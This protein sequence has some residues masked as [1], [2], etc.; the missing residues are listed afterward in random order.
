M[1]LPR[2]FPLA[3]LLLLGVATMVASAPLTFAAR[4]ALVHDGA[5]SVL[6]YAGHHH[7][8]MQ[9]RVQWSPPAGAGGD[10]DGLDA[11]LHLPPAHP[12]LLRD[13]TTGWYDGAS[14]L[15]LERLPVR[16][17][18]LV[19]TL[20]VAVAPS[21]SP[22][23]A[24]GEP[25]LVLAPTS[26]LWQTFGAAEFSGA[27][28]RLWPR[29]LPSRSPSHDPHAEESAGDTLLFGAGLT[30]RVEIGGA[31]WTVAVEWA[32]DAAQ[33]LLPAALYA[34]LRRAP[35]GTALVLCAPTNRLVEVVM[36]ADIDDDRSVALWPAVDSGQNTIRLGRYFMSARVVGWRVT[37]AGVVTAVVA[38]PLPD[39][40]SVAAAVLGL[41]AVALMTYVTSI[42]G[43]T[44]TLQPAYALFDVQPGRCCGAA[45]DEHEHDMDGAAGL[46]IPWA[47]T[48]RIVALGALALGAVLHGLA[49]A[50]AGGGLVI[51]TA[52]RGA[53]AKLAVATASVAG[54]YALLLLMALVV[55]WVGSSRSRRLRSV[56]R[57]VLGATLA[58]VSARS[59][60]AAL[61]VAAAGRSLFGLLVTTGAAVA[62]VLFPTA[63]ALL[64]AATQTVHALAAP[65]RA[66]WRR[67]H[68]GALALA[69]LAVHAGALVTHML[70]MYW[71]LLVPL[72]DVCNS[73]YAPGAS[74]SAAMLVL[75]SVALA[76]AFAVAHEAR[77]VADLAG[78]KV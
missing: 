75:G 28:L 46:R 33:T 60:V 72:F 23:A 5:V 53:L 63:Y 20:T 43:P 44:F 64:V 59:V 61:L 17:R 30:H 13:A 12:I 32:P 10:G 74:D 25:H 77:G 67:H 15:S 3:V 50:Y 70:T 31:R 34:A 54:A 51:D 27:A 6:L 65:D 4:R 40:V 57:R 47:R 21:G 22:A 18:G 14:A 19:S 26:A 45:T 36:A 11:A 35:A 37:A 58:A 78:K 7:R 73:V 42:L 68:G 9:P 8:Q 52:L 56:H 1:T 62:L 69:L 16:A 24:S 2:L 38:A 71:W 55:D 29:V 41:A 49:V 66:L 48:V 76:V 39:G